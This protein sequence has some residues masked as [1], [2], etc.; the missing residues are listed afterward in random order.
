MENSTHNPHQDTVCARN[1]ECIF[2]QHFFFTI[3]L[4]FLFFFYHCI[5]INLLPLSSF[6]SFPSWAPH[7]VLRIGSPPLNLAAPSLFPCSLWSLCRPPLS[8]SVWCV[9]LWS[10]CATVH[11]VDRKHPVHH[12]SQLPVGS[13]GSVWPICVIFC[14]ITGVWLCVIRTSPNHLPGERR[15]EAGERKVQIGQWALHWVLCLGGLCGADTGSP[16]LS[17][18]H[19]SS[20]PTKDRGAPMHG[21]VCRD[22]F[23]VWWW[24][25]YLILCDI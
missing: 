9:T 16:L 18:D 15:R 4:L 20:C 6:P 25:M 11:P 22:E 12:R 24:F 13:A 19:Y 5:S 23:Q 7:T 3:V 2:F 1:N 17:W 14:Q 10:F 8:G 21:K